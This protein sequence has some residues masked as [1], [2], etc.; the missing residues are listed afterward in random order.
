M[1]PRAAL[2]KLPPRWRKRLF[3]A[4]G[5]ALA[6][7]VMGFLILPVIVRIVAERQLSRLLHR[8]VTIQKVLLN[9]YVLSGTVRGLLIKDRDGD[10][11]LAWQEVYGNLQLRS[12]FGR[13][14]VFKEVRVVEPFVRVQVNK[15]HTLNFSDVLARLAEA[16]Q[17][18]PRAKPSKPLALRVDSLRIIRAEA[19]YT[20]LTPSTPFHRR[21]GPVELTLVGFHTDPGVTNP[22][23]FSGVTDSGETLSWSG[24]FSL[25]PLRSQGEFSVGHVSLA[26][27]APLYQDI[28]RFQ[29]QGGALDARAAYEV[30]WSQT[31]GV[32]VLTNAWFHLHGFR[33]A[34]KNPAT[35]VAE[36]ADLTV[37]GASA[38][39][40]ARRAQVDSISVNGASLQVQRTAEGK[41]NVV[42]L[43]QPIGT[44]VPDSVLLFLRSVTNVF[45][46][47]L[48]STNTAQGLV[49]T[50]ELRD[51]ELR[52]ED[53]ANPRP[54]RLAL[55]DISL[56]AT[57][58][59]NLPGANLTAGVSLRWNTNGSINASATASIDPAGAEARFTVAGLELAPLGPYLDQ[60]VSVFI[61]GSSLSMDGKVTLER[62]TGPNP[63][64]TFTGNFRLDGFGSVDSE[65]GE[66]LL[67][68]SEANF[69]DVKT[70]LSPPEF[71]VHELALRDLSAQ[72]VLETND[73]LNLVRVIRMLGTNA[74][75]QP[76]APGR[77]SGSSSP[78]HPRKSFADLRRQFGEMLSLYSATNLTRVQVPVR[79]AVD[80]VVLSNAAVLLTDRS[81]QPEVR[82]ALG[83]INGQVTGLSSDAHTEI[84][85]K[86]HA[87]V[88]KTGPADLTA[89]LP[90]PGQGVTNLLKAVLKNVDLNPAGT[91]SRKY[92]GYALR[93]GKLSLDI[94]YQMTGRKIKA[95][96][97]VQL[98]QFTLGEK[99]QSPDATKLPVK[100]AVALLK[101][102]NGRIELDVPVEGDLDDPK[103]RLG[104]VIT[105]ALVN[106][107][108][109]IVTSPFAALG[110]LFGGKG[111]EV[112]FQEFQPGSAEL[113]Q[114]SIQKLDAV[115][116][117][118]Y[119]RPGLEL[120]MEGS[121]DSSA[122][123]MVL[124]RRALETQFKKK[125]W[126]RLR[127][128]EQERVSFSEV[129]LTSDEY[130][131]FLQEAHLQR[132]AKAA[133]E[134]PV[135]G[136][137]DQ[138]QSSAPPKA[139]RGGSHSTQPE[140]RKGA[141]DMMKQEIPTAPL[142]DLEREALDAIE[143]SDSDYRTLADER[144]QTVK[145]YILKSGKVEAERLF[146]AEPNGKSAS[147]NGSRVYLHI[148]S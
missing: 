25:F 68:F 50:L 23:S 140:A 63:N 61:V 14:W 76:A 16:Q 4:V 94:D 125:K 39:A 85:V 124:R 120:E 8:E 144:A 119:E 96:N 72:V 131:A 3:W 51:C 88:D 82:A 10:R 28:V 31:N 66:D 26:Q 65:T 97:A 115:I 71:S 64:A 116:N 27:Y 52:F 40:L 59:S 12:F 147:T 135:T 58:L 36:V 133:S 89:S 69:A 92:L 22:Y 18:N 126:A 37:A 74:P 48:S 46:Q 137:P 87:A 91:Y 38:D 123:G 86:L 108:T 107:I 90:P 95:R 102:R 98:D 114:A 7:T 93:K 75:V 134:G 138:P 112:S 81:V 1:T 83:N 24:Q 146:L 113:S 118:L 127:K 122:D 121:I 84:A 142:P 80:T 56:G 132:L 34:D 35:N 111:E 43:A 139:P 77:D 110:S 45:A 11:F 6:Y 60:F 109:K 73:T 49:R 21:L 105:H 143:L 117:A 100:L 79:V 42:E 2:E 130:A 5:L 141:E 32:A 101:D 145:E 30:A 70:Q 15:D 78:A 53:L 29:I 47:F 129:T 9:P 55:T 13:P 41:L 20:D 57:N 103:F 148:R 136:K 17:Q 104:T 67:K 99:A 62:P 128:S 54:V 19:S 106:V 44:N 33:V